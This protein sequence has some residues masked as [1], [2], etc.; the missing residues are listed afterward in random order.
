MK[1]K[2]P[3]CHTLSLEAIPKLPRHFKVP[4]TFSKMRGVGGEKQHTIHQAGEKADTTRPGSSHDSNTK[5]AEAEYPQNQGSVWRRAELTE[6]TP[7]RGLGMPHLPLVR[8]GQHDPFRTVKVGHQN[9]QNVLNLQKAQ[10]ETQGQGEKDKSGFER[11]KRGRE[12]RRDGFR[13]VECWRRAKVNNAA[14]HLSQQP[15]AALP[16]AETN[17]KEHMQKFPERWLGAFTKS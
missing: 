3:K 16:E 5:H 7:D 12:A 11:G 15:L 6:S 1:L 14:C 2:K 4:L 9:L 10:R 13:E 17:A 8:W